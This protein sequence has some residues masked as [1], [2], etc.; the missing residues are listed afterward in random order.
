M[1]LSPDTAARRFKV[2]V[3]DDEPTLRLGFSYAL[4][5]HDTETAAGGREALIRIGEQDFDVVILDLRMPDIDGL[6]VIEMLRR[7][8]NP[9]PVVLCSAALTPSSALRAITGNVVDFLLKPVRPAELRGVIEHVLNP[10]ED[11]LSQALAKARAGNLNQAI[12]HLEGAADPCAR[13]TV[14][15]SVLRAIRLGGLEGE[16][17]AFAKLEREGLD[18]LAFRAEG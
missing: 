4:A 11:V 2:L 6:Q 9:L 16:A 1:S 7:Q 14:W 12:Q 10:G 5:E 18:Q 3:V 15:T 8:D 13:T 17:A